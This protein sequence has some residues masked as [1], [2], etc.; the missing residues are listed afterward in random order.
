MLK[1]IYS[2][3]SA[4]VVGLN[5]QN[6]ISHNI[7]N[8]DTPGFKQILVSMDDYT[9]TAVVPTT[10]KNVTGSFRLPVYDQMALSKLGIGNRLEYVGDLGL[11]VMNSPEQTDFEQGS[12]Q[13]TNEELDMAIQ[14]SGFFRVNTPDGERYTRDGRFTLDSNGTLVTPDGY[15]VLDENGQQ[16][17][18][19]DGVISVAG[20]GTL[21]VDGVPGPKIGLAGFKEPASELA[22]DKGNYFIA[23]GSPTLT[24]EES[25][26]VHQGVL[27]AANVNVA[28]VMTQMISI[29]RNYEAAQQLGKAIGTLGSI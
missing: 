4:M 27:E 29:Q 25:G 16:I 15:Q 26:E 2:A 1:G 21:S 23:A 24:Q 10:G 28:Q 6:V 18:L 13:A 14:G 7:A 8:L 11:G 22:R 19:Q 3:A 17:T 5:R 9:K 12:L 20:D